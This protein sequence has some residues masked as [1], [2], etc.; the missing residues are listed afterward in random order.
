[1]TDRERRL[2]QRIDDLYDEVTS[3]RAAKTNGGRRRRRCVYCGRL[4]RHAAC[5]AHLDLLALDP[6][7]REA[8]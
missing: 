8:A 6:Y 4:S 1:M 7:Y 3:L 2:R 5:G